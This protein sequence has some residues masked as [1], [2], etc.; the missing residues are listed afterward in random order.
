[1]KNG[2]RYVNASNEENEPLVIKCFHCRDYHRRDY[3][4]SEKKMFDLGFNNGQAWVMFTILMERH[5]ARIARDTSLIDYYKTR[6][7]KAEKQVSE[8]AKEIVKL[9]ETKN[10][11]TNNDQRSPGKRK[12]HMG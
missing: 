10:A 7:E 11:E 2:E 12:N 6:A 4:C 9:K 1:M 3:D 8:Y 5:E